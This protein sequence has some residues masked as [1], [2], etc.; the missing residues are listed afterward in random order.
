MMLMFWYWCKCNSFS[1]YSSPFN[2]CSLLE[3]TYWLISHFG[4]SK[5]PDYFLTLKGGLSDSFEQS[6][7]YFAS[8]STITF[9]R[10]I[11]GTN[12]DAIRLQCLPLQTVLVISVVTP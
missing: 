10:I 2:V 11:V 8:S 5:Q 3:K 12:V 4:S 9:F 1:V 7:I 6:V